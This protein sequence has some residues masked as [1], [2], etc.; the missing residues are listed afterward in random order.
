MNTVIQSTELTAEQKAM[1]DAQMAASN[2]VLA[3][4]ATS[5]W[6]EPNVRRLRE[7][8]L[9][10]NHFRFD[11]DTRQAMMTMLELE[12]VIL[13]AYLGV[14]IELANAFYWCKS[15]F[16][17]RPQ[18]DEE[19]YGQ[20][21][22]LAVIDAM[23]CFDG[24]TKFC[25]YVY[26]AIKNRLSAFMRDHESHARVGR[27]IKKLRDRVRVLMRDKKCDFEE[28]ILYLRKEM[29][30]EGKK[31]SETTT[32][33]IKSSMYKVRH[34]V[35]ESLPQKENK[36]SNDREEA[37]EIIASAVEQ[38]KLKG[39]EKELVEAYL[40]GEQGFQAKFTLQIN[41]NTGRLYTRQAVNQTWLRVCDKLRQLVEARR[42]A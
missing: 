1:L 10:G 13:S 32:K 26:R 29:K 33:K 16:K 7:E 21:A 23:Y 31:L 34:D 15:S 19:D 27:G 17:G 38:A 5:W 41:P 3:K 40:A 12:P 22:S 14:Q 35:I 36:E 39:L 24:R 18:L 11:A 20:E 8:F 30:K 25:T 9:A 6:N 28:A 42:A 4:T 37:H 2:M